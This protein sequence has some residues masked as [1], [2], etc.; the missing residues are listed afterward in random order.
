MKFTKSQIKSF[1]RLVAQHDGLDILPNARGIPR[2]DRSAAYPVENRGRVGWF[3][4]VCAVSAPTET[5]RRYHYAAVV[6][7]RRPAN[8][9][10]VLR[11]LE[12]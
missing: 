12:S 7:A 2:G 8:A 4:Q 6:R 3:R 5:G 10:A 11:A 1:N 9:A